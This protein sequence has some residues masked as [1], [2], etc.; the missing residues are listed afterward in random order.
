MKRHGWRGI[1]VFASMVLAPAMP[2]EPAR[3]GLPWDWSHTWHLY[4]PDMP[5]EA[6][7][8]GEYEEWLRLWADPRF[9]HAVIRKADA[10]AGREAA[11]AGGP[12]AKARG[13]NGN[14]NGHPRAATSMDRDWSNLV[15][16]GSGTAADFPAKYSFDISATPD[17]VNDFIIVPMA[18]AGNSG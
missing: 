5:A 2:E 3:V 18:A 10:I 7:A 4:N 6:M 8:K 13:G 11:L 14:G 17:C 9:K 16:S 1:L 15:G 12:Q